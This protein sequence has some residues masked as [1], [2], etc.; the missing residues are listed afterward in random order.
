MRFFKPA[1]PTSDLPGLQSLE[2]TDRDRVAQT[3]RVVHIPRS[4]SLIHDHE[5]SDEA[6]LVLEGTM[7]VDN[8][9]EHVA[10]IGP[11]GFAGEMGLV[12]HRLR[13]ARVTTVGDVVALAFPRDDFQSLREQIPAFDR[14]V[15][16]S[17]DQRRDR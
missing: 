7:R 12:D 2:E 5:P 17:A 13:N 4:W 6:Y 9:G 10:D 16:E 14:L 15:R 8:G 3:G 11:G 1:A